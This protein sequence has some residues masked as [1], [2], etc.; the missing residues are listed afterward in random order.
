MERANKDMKGKPHW[1]LIPVYPLEVA[2]RVFT[3]ALK[4]EGGKYEA[5][6]WRK[7]APWSEIIAAI[8]RHIAS[9]EALEELDPESQESHLGHL[10]C[11][12]MML[13][14]YTILYPQYDDRP[15]KVVGRNGK[16]QTKKR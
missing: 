14:E 3:K 7:G 8:K 16:I 13:L 11:D 10:I 5:H 4:S 1:D 6:N 2:A 9:F 12:A 15:K